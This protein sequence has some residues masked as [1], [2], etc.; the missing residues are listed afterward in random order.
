MA[1]SP[2]PPPSA[3]W[4]LTVADHED[5]LVVRRRDLTLLRRGHPVAGPP[6]R[7]RRRQRRDPDRSHGA[8]D[9]PLGGRGETLARRGRIPAARLPD[10]GLR[11]R[12][13]AAG[14]AH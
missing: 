3:R 12:R 2:G 7:R 9:L 11:R 5:D 14:P 10:R 13:P 6:T 4:P 1:L 8:P